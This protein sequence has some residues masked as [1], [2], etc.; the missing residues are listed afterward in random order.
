MTSGS[1]GAFITNTTIEI[2]IPDGLI[3]LVYGENGSNLARV[4]QVNYI[5]YFILTGF[6]VRLGIS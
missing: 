5:R 3:G 2:K 1:I 4:R 6:S